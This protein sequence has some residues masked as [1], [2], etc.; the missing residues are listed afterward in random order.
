MKNGGSGSSERRVEDRPIRAL[1]LYA[2][3]SALGASLG[4]FFRDTQ[5]QGIIDE[6]WTMSAPSVGTW[7]ARGRPEKE[8]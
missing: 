4:R 5:S 2:S 3:A 1:D 6:R 8:S 7:S